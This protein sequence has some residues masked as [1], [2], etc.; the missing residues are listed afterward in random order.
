MVKVSQINVIYKNGSTGNLSFIT[1]L[2]NVFGT[3]SRIFTTFT[4]LN[5]Y[6]LL[7]NYSTGAILNIIIILQFIYYWNVHNKAY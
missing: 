4:E 3:L 7:L 2:I 1:N 6:M 5:D